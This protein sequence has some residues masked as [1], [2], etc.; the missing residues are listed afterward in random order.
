MTLGIS[1]GIVSHELFSFTVSLV[2][3]SIAAT[4]A[5]IWVLNKLF[6]IAPHPGHPATSLSKEPIS[7][8]VVICGFGRV[9]FWVGEALKRQGIPLVIID[10]HHQALHQARRL[11]IPFVYGDAT[12][13]EVLKAADIANAR[14]VVITTPDIKNQERILRFVKNINPALYIIARAHRPEDRDRLTGLGAQAVIQPEFEA[15]L[16]IIHRILQE[17]GVSREVVS[18][19][20][21]AI[22]SES[23]ALA[24]ESSK[25][26]PS[27]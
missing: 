8:H 18:Q 12:E 14:A 21:R 3:F 27:F 17:I 13:P 10:Y 4:P 1:L 26:S 20:V 7:D 23:R 24:S 22:R 2:L 16:S 9:G 5:F 25:M 11:D 6:S 19:T 15:S